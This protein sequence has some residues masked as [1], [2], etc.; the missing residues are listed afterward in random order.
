MVAINQQPTH[1]RAHPHRPAHPH[2]HQP[3]H[4]H[5]TTT[6]PPH[7]HP[8]IPIAVPLDHTPPVE[9]R[10]IPYVLCCRARGEHPSPQPPTDTHLPPP[11]WGRG[12]WTEGNS[13][14]PI[15][16]LQPATYDVRLALPDDLWGGGR[17]GSAPPIPSL[18]PATYDVRLALPDDL[19][20][21]GGQEAPL[22]SPRPNRS[23]TPISSHLVGVGEM[24]GR[25]QR[26]PHP[27][28]PACHL[29]CPSCAP[30]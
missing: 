29:R 9:P 11:R 21:V 6:N 5:T 14:P 26:P 19:W 10:G 23:P 3:V 7:P 2:H 24:D 4:N 12:R 18:Q 27:L 28:A 15:P 22:P 30:R 17:S 20:G 13:T 1:N 16:P 8:L 25:E